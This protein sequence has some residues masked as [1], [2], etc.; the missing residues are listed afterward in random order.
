MNTVFVSIAN[1]GSA[2]SV[3]RT[4]LV[5]RLLDAHESVEVVLIS[6]LVNDPAFVREFEH[7]R[8]RFEE[9]RPHRP[10]G[11][12]ARLMAL[13]QAA[14]IGSGV[15][16]SVQNPARRGGGKEVHPLD[17]REASVD[18]R[19]GAF[20]GAHVNPLRADRSA[21]FTSRCRWVVRSLS[22]GVARRVEPRV[23][24]RRGAAASNG[25][26]TA[27]ALDGGGSELGQLYKQAPAGASR[28][29][30]RRLERFDE[31]AGDRPAWLRARGSACCRRAAMGRLLSA[32]R[33]GTR[34]VPEEDR[35]RSVTAD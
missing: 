14:Y 23:D 34:C 33:S 11:L 20:D 18:P 25:G 3:L 13:V 21:D 15:S 26:A 19:A 5:A 6:P 22:A 29:P 17:W 10:A 32:H 2:G 9:L 7:R 8:V 28:E 16:E 35:R 4:G 27:R 31:A 12:E 24:L 1:G 30:P